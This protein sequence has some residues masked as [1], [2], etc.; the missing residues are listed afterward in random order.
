MQ[1]CVL[2]AADDFVL[3]AFESRSKGGHTI[4]ILIKQTLDLLRGA[5][6]LQVNRYAVPRSDFASINQSIN[7]FALQG[8]SLE[9]TV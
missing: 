3:L 7:E 2:C 1:Q 8:F 6:D 5:S 9:H 4:T